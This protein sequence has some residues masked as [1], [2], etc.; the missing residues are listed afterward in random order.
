MMTSGLEHSDPESA[1]EGHGCE[2][3]KE[4]ARQWGSVGPGERVRHLVP[5]VD[6]CADDKC[7][8]CDPDRHTEDGNESGD[9]PG[10]RGSV[11]LTSLSAEQGWR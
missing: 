1:D 11:H 3:E 4:A 5:T 9:A 2:A 10:S 8:T 7:H 6:K